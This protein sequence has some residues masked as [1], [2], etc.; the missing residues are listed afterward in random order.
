MEHQIK[1]AVAFIERYI[2][3]DFPADAPAREGGMSY[4]HFC[5]AFTAMTGISPGMYVRRR[6]L[7]IAAERLR[8]SNMSVIDIALDSGFDSHEAF[9]R[10]FKS[11]FG[12]NPRDFRGTD[13]AYYHLL[14]PIFDDAFLDH[15][16]SQSITLKPEERR[17]KGAVVTGL[18]QSYHFGD[19]PHDLNRLWQRFNARQ[20]EIDPN[21]CCEIAYGICTTDT[22]KKPMDSSFNYI[23]G[24]A[25]DDVDKPK[26]M[27]TQTIPTATYWVYT[28]EGDLASFKDTI[29]YIW[30]VSLP[31]NKKAPTHPIDFEL[32]D[33]RFD[34]ETLTGQIEVWIP[35]GE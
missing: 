3:E 34:V 7:S 14:Q 28:H 29:A 16:F 12:M 33:E 10:A 30:G 22:S 11:M 6:R 5:R 15:I 4:Y 1:R 32:Y 27:V 21:K 18:C 31:K 24:L 9:T 19:D 23:A 8:T 25:V 2:G 20:A 17:F 26:D 35:I 13:T